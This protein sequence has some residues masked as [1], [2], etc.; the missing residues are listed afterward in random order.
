MVTVFATT[1]SDGIE[2][3]ACFEVIDSGFILHSRG[4]NKGPSAINPDYSKALRAL[5]QRLADNSLTIDRAWVDSSRV[6]HLPL[7]EREILGSNDRGASP[8]EIFKRMTKR[9]QLIGKSSTG[10]GGNATKKIRVQL[11]VS[12]PVAA[13]VGAL[14]AVEARP[15]NRS[16]NCLP[17]TET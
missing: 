4:G 1:D 15:D 12:V 9:M 3:D 16:L 10:L 2:F 13:L 17:A 7:Y 8:E 11:D 6:Q 14:Q 5:L